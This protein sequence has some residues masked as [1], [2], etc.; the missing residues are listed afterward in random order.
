MSKGLLLG[1]GINGRL[2]IED[3]SKDRIRQRFQNNI[4]VY[5]PIIE[6]FFGVKINNE[7]YSKLCGESYG[8]ESHAS[9]LYEYIKE[10][11][12]TEWIDNDECIVQD[13]ISAI[14][15]T[16]IFYN[17]EGKIVVHYD[18]SKMLQIDKY[19]Y[20]YTLNYV[21]FWDAK[22]KSMYLHGKIDFD[23]L[24]DVKNAILISKRMMNNKGYAE[25][26]KVL[27]ES[28]NIVEFCS[29]NIIFAPS[30]IQKS[31]LINV[32]G[33]LPSQN[34]FPSNDLFLYNPKQL[35]NDLNMVKELDI[36][37]VSPYGDDN[38]IDIV[39]CMSEVC[40]YIYDKSSN[41][42]EEDEWKK[43]L[44]CSYELLDSGNI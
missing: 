37:G 31:N 38:L 13:V 41:K 29:D 32:T 1:N 9:S 42:E 20:I 21:E 2:G 26:V 39:N 27:K 22:Q 30:K 17:R 11:K 16:S 43:K 35:Y 40:V 6:T 15:C 25:A 36:F 7:F 33:I 34:L 19:D 5:S 8:I 14:C 12:K 24:E 23:A 10:N 28:C 44:N 4:D 18:K 3:L